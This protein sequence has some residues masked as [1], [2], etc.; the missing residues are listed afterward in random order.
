MCIFFFNHNMELQLF[1]KL[2][3][4][5]TWIFVLFFASTSS[6]NDVPKI[7]LDK[8]VFVRFK[9]ENLTIGCR[10]K[11]PPN[12]T[13][14]TLKCFDPS[15]KPIHSSVII[16]KGE[17]V[18]KSF[19]LENMEISGEYHCQ[20]QTAKAYWFLRVRDHG[21]KDIVKLDHTFTVVAVF[22]GVLLVFSVVGSVY[23]FRGH[24]KCGNAGDERTQNREERKLEDDT[25]EVSSPS[26]S[27]YASL[28]A[29]PGSIYDVLD[30]SAANTQPEQR[31][32]KP[33][34]DKI[35][36][37]MVQTTQNQDEGIFESVY[38]NF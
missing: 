13:Q 3:F 36:K 5:F 6:G 11:K 22:T 15:T 25:N 30:H 27:F 31:K 37:P 23:V 33:K 21:Y 38:E 26:T 17:E 9:G 34:K 16:D 29:R 7:Y 18:S 8:T 32:A 24:W 10:L 14:G 28:E 19:V 20:Y 2:S 1:Y 4:I 35:P 12:Q